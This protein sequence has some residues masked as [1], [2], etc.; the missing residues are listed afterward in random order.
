[1]VSCV[2]NM[3]F[4]E[5]QPTKDNNEFMFKHKYQG[6]YESLTDSSILIVSEFKIVQKWDYILKFSKH[7]LDSI[8]DINFKNETLNYR[9]V[10]ITFTVK[11]DG[12][13]AIV[14][15]QSKET[16]FHISNSNI[17]RYYKNTY[18]LNYRNS[19]NLYKVKILDL[20]RKGELIFKS[21]QTGSQSIS[22]L[23]EI[24]TIDSLNKNDYTVKPSKREIRKLL[25]SDLFAED[26]KFI[27]LDQ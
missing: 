26:S 22:S 20:N 9:D 16:I 18:F 23:K 13:S 2:P 14:R 19:N 4:D 27:K 24:I 8:E 17:L 21:L 3:Y 6:V 1:M 15:V 11:V 25:R 12:D 5:P 10:G 7:D